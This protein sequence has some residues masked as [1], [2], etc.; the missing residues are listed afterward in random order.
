M[1]VRMEII[2]VSLPI[3]QFG[4]VNRVVAKED[5]DEIFEAYQ[6]QKIVEID[7][8][9]DGSAVC[10]DIC[11]CVQNAVVTADPSDDLLTWVAGFEGETQ[12]FWDQ[13]CLEHDEASYIARYELERIISPVILRRGGD[14]DS[15][16][17][18]SLGVVTMQ[19]RIDKTHIEV[20]LSTAGDDSRNITVRFD[21]VII[22]DCCGIT[23]KD[24]KIT[25]MFDQL[26]VEQV[27]FAKIEPNNNNAK[28]FD[29][30]DIS[31]FDNLTIESPRKEGAQ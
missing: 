27:P 30:E 19:A 8:A 25:T 1:K 21:N 15:I 4:H 3:G 22:F 16:G 11:D 6:D 7:N 23:L 10:I 20:K 12:Q 5:W 13:V 28:E 18:T 17:A 24:A 31:E 9:F 26:K 2:V 29:A 14:V